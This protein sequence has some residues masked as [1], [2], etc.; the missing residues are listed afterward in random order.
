MLA[1]YLASIG[2]SACHIHVSDAW[3]SHPS[4]SCALCHIGQIKVLEPIVQV[5]I[6]HIE[7]HALY[8][9]VYKSTPVCVSHLSI[10]LTRAPPRCGFASPS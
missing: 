8:T 4:E 9:P 2:A 10:I 1:V 7:T 3:S 6:P 5:E